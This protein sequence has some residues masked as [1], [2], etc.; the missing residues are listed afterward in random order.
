MLWKVLIIFVGGII[1]DMLATRYTRCVAKGQA[2]MAAALSGLI[3][4]ANLAL[5]GTILQHAET[6]GFYGVVAMAGGSSVGTLLG[7]RQRFLG[8]PPGPP[9]SP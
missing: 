4:L 6:L 3:T 2:K 5:W 9:G 8:A 7:F 1:L